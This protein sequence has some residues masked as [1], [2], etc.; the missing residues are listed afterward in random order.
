[1]A[2]TIR[3][4]AL[5][6]RAARARLKQQGKKPHFK[7]LIPGKLH[8]GYRRKK[9]D[10][11]G[12]W[13]VRRYKGKERYAVAP[14]GLADDFQDADD[15][16]LSFED[17]QRA[18]H[19]Y[20]FAEAPQR[21]GGIT[22]AD[23][24][25]NYIKWAKLDNK[26]TAIGME[27]RAS[28]HILPTLGKVRVAELTTADL[29]Q[30]RDELA[31]SLA[32]FRPKAGQPH[33]TKPAA[34]TSQRARKVTANKSITILKAALNHAFHHDDVA[35]DK[36]WRKFKSF[37]KV[38][39]VRE[40]ALTVQEAERLINASDEPSGFR[41]MVHAGLQTGCRYGELCALLVGDFRDDKIAV[42][43]SKSGKPR[44]VRLTDEGKQFFRQLTAGRDPEEIMLRNHRLGREWHKSEQARPMREACKHA[45]IKPPIG[46]HQLRHTWASLAVMNGV[47]LLV[48]ANNLGHADT[49]MVEKHY[50]H[51]TA[52][53]MDEAI[54]AGAPRFGAV[55]P[56]NVRVMI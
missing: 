43:M 50:G 15:T 18:A 16:H 37:R 30:W 8:L 41:D 4:S 27:R 26:A 56:S 54:L 33:K 42:R 55:Q 13:I 5:G 36:A 17:A 20:R 38:D 14:L 40:R 25:A 51:L 11:P 23:A 44:Y 31:A 46:F 7:T 10:E 6:T 28:L 9:K 32:L 47:P 39:A 29:N 53:Y 1:M 35:D 45:T 49:R 48:V 12:Q 22:V 3:D 24:I 21:R 19:A 34:K 52:D 2:R